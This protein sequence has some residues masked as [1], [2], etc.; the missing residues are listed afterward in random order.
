MPKNPFFS[1]ATCLSDAKKHLAQS[2]YE[3]STAIQVSNDECETLTQPI[4][5][6]AYSTRKLLQ[7]NEG[8]RIR[9]NVKLRENSRFR[10]QTAE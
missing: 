7:K 9:Y 8:T 3:L 5:S 6:S 2:T 1:T 4:R 10:G